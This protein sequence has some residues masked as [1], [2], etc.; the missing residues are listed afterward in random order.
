MATR[1]SLAGYLFLMQIFVQSAGISHFFAGFQ[2][3][4]GTGREG[5]K[6]VK[7]GC[8]LAIRPHAGKLSC[9]AQLYI[10]VVSLSS[11]LWGGGYCLCLCVS[12]KPH[13]LIYGGFGR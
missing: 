11:L 8:L 6:K 2:R 1:S 9:L 7:G 5:F 13:G 4:M 10:A 12:L 3:S